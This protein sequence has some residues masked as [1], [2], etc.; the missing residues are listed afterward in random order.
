MRYNSRVRLTLADFYYELFVS[1]E[2]MAN[3]VPPSPASQI[4]L[5]DV[6]PLLATGTH[7]SRS[8]ERLLLSAVSLHPF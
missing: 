1:S 3:G 2:G 5:Q 8:H 6:D 4:F 7:S